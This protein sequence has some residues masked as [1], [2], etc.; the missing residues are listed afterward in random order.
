MGLP[1]WQ[2]QSVSTIKQKQRCDVET[3]LPLRI[4]GVSA[5][6][7]DSSKTL[8]IVSLIEMAEWRMFHRELSF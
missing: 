7:V 4:Y 8:E 1:K 3:L 2:T 5:A 6:R